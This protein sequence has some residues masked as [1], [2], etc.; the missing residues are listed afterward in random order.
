MVLG[1]QVKLRFMIDQLGEFK[2]MSLLKDI[3]NLFLTRR[4]LKKGEVSQMYRIETNSF[5]KLPLIINYINNFNL[6]TKKKLSFDK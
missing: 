6:K 5:I 2:A 4:I 3:L 1:Y